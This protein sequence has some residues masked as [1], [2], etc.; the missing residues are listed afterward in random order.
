MCIVF[1]AAGLGGYLVNCGVFYLF[2]CDIAVS[3]FIVTDGG[4]LLVVTLLM[5]RTGSTLQCQPW[6]SF[7]LGFMGYGSLDP[8]L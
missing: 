3:S 5:L 8:P 6:T 4:F 1:I 2:T 7:Q